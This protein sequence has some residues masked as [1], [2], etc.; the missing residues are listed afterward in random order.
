MS[1]A[2]TPARVP[3][4]GRILS[5]ELEARGWTQTD[6]A[7]IMNRPPQAISEI[8]NAKKQITPETAIELA[9][10]LD[11]SPEFWINLEANYQ[12][13]LARKNKT[14]NTI[15][16]RRR[17]FEL[18]PVT[19]L[20]KKKWIKASDSI[21]EL[22]RELCAFLDIASPNDCPTA[23]AS[24]RHS[25]VR[26]PEAAAQVAWLKR[27][28]NLARE[29]PINP[30]KL[31]ELRLNLS[32]LLSLT[33][34]L[35]GVREVPDFLH[36]FGVHFLIVPHLS[37]TYIDGAAFRLDDHPVIA[38]TL[39]YDRIDN[40]W[41]TLLHELAHLLLDHEDV[42]FDSILG[43]DDEVLDE[44]EL[45]A[46]AQARDW[47]IS[48]D[49]YS[50]FVSRFDFSKA[51]ILEFSEEIKRHPGIVVGRLQKEGILEYRQ[52][53]ALLERVSP[54]LADWI[55]RLVEK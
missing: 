7:A 41:F 23:L 15:E 1:Q 54:V 36:G 18:A 5:Q 33:W 51:A 3:P 39:R 31:D 50:A 40:F 13:H 14:N 46:N 43:K 21:D 30:L 10:A 42:Y 9:P 37:K 53:R 28:E 34:K 32:S 24:F 27:V 52:Q 2:L 38:L 45:E 16:R 19:E 12:L 48:T 44:P 11:T 47:L 26:G 6:L 8:I 49:A 20:I 25:E 29:Q 4:P 17:L 35:E 55:D 22:E